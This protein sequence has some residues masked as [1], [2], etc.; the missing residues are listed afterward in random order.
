MSRPEYIKCISD[1]HE[2]NKGKSWC[3]RRLFAEFAFV[4]ADHAAMNG[5]NNGRLVACAECTRLIMAAMQ[6]GM[7][8]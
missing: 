6:N 2:D 5:R 4:D 3:G 8:E 7:D 1:T